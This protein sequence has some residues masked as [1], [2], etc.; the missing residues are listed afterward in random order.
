MKELFA[1][2]A[3]IPLAVKGACSDNVIAFSRKKGNFS[4]IVVVPRFLTGLMDAQN[5]WAKAEIDWSDTFI[6]LPGSA[7]TAWT[8]VFTNRTISSQSD[9]LPVRDVLDP[10]PVALLFAGGFNG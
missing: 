7:S 3:Y 1:G 5:S 9:E 2:G 4:A 8:E 6:R 10:F